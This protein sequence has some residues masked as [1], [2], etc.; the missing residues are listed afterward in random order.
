MKGANGMQVLEGL[1]NLAAEQNRSPQQM[2]PGPGILSPGMLGA[3]KGII[4]SQNDERNF[5]NNLYQT[6]QSIGGQSA[7]NQ[8]RAGGPMGGRGVPVIGEESSANGDAAQ[9]RNTRS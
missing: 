5:V 4:G 1:G 8:W 2:R 7:N 9:P 6:G 3:Q